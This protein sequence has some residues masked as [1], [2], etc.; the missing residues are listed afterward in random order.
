MLSV[1]LLFIILYFS[2]LLHCTVQWVYAGYVSVWVQLYYVG[3]H[4]LTL[5]VSAYM[6]IFRCLGYFIFICLKE[7]ASLFLF[8]FFS[9]GHTLHVSICVFLCCFSL[10]ET[11]RGSL[12]VKAL[13]YK[14]GDRGFEIR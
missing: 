7:S 9:C 14:P 1:P 13:S 8:A 6:A 3:F 12:V 2:I 10:L 4:C 11:T 5:H